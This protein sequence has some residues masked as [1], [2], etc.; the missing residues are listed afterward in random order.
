MKILKNC[1]FNGTFPF[2]FNL[3]EKVKIAI[4]TKVI[5]KDAADAVE[6]VLLFSMVPIKVPETAGSVGYERNVVATTQ[7]AL[8]KYLHNRPCNDAEI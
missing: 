4:N 6:A 8:L 1:G 7:N 3:P 5:D 2:T